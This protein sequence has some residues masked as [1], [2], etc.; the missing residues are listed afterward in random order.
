MEISKNSSQISVDHNIMNS[1]NFGSQFHDG[2]SQDMI[3]VDGNKTDLNEY[4]DDC[5]LIEQVRYNFKNYGNIL[6]KAESVK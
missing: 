4:A 6:S 3:I 1:K 5:F 2:T